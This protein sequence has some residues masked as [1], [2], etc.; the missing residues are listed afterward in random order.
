MARADR[1]TVE[2][3]KAIAY[4]DFLPNL[5]RNPLTGLLAKVTNEDSVKQ[6]I[7]NLCK[8]NRRERY[9]QPLTGSKLNGSLFENSSDPIV[10]DEIKSTLEQTIADDEPRATNVSVEVSN[11]P[12]DPNS[13]RAFITFSIK[14]ISEPITLIVVLKRVR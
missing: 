3:K 9:N 2:R 10:L 4:S 14:N 13:I 11:V 5:D 6:S 12:D 7:A 1:F 8:T